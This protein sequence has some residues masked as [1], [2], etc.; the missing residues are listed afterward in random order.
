MKSLAVA[1]VA[2]LALAAFMV[3]AA[4]GAYFLMQVR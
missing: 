2:I 3:L 1:F 4:V